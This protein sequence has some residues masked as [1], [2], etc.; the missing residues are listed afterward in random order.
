MLD[1]RDT[2]LFIYIEDNKRE[3]LRY[4]QV[5]IASARLVL[6]STIR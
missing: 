1:V 2:S 4:L 3:M 5:R 6:T